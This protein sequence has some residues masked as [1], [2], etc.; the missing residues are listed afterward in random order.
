ML[1]FERRVVA[2]MVDTLD[3]P[4]QASVVAYVDGAL[5]AMPQHLRLGVAGE[6][7]LFGAWATAQRARGWSTARAVDALDHSPIALVRQWVRLLRSL[8]LFAQY[9][10]APT[11]PPARPA[12]P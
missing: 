4:R 3:P 7:M 6:S 5:G 10:L 2:S 9:E 8:A 11:P 12:A 1:W